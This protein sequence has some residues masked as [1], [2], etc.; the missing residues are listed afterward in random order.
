M[1]TRPELEKEYSEWMKRMDAALDAQRKADATVAGLLA[2][3]EKM[4]TEPGW[5]NP[6][7]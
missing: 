4:M 6:P 2:E 1:K 3:R 5:R 7:R